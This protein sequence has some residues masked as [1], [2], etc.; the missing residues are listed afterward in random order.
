MPIP[1][2]D[3]GDEVRA[4][5]YVAVYAAYVEEAIED[6]YGHLKRHDPRPNGDPW[7][8]SR[9]IDSCRRAIAAL[10]IR[11]TLEEI[12]T[13]MGLAKELLRDRNVAIH[14]PLYGL[15]G[16]GNLRQIRG[17]ARG[18]WF[19]TAEEIYAL[20]ERL[21]EGATALRAAKVRLPRAIHEALRR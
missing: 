2:K 9:R 12:R 13:D 16:G 21:F 7:Q 4:M 14:S 11:E 8:S 19:E 18:H 1:R 15:P 20:A 10:P 17:P 5:G 6:C 3:D